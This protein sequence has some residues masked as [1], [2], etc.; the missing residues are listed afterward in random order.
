MKSSRQL[1]ANFGPLKGANANA[2][3]TGP[4]GDTMEFWLWVAE[5]RILQANFTTDGCAASIASGAMTAGFADG[6]TLAAAEIISPDQV[7]RAL[8]GLPP[9]HVHCPL[10]AVNTLQA[11]LA[12]YRAHP[13]PASGPPP[14]VACAPPAAAPS[15]AAPLQPRGGHGLLPDEEQAV[16][17]RVSRIAHKLVVLSGKGGVGKSTVAANLAV[18]L[19]AAGQ[20][21]GLLDVDVHG[22]SIPKLLGLEGRKPEA[23]DEELQPISVNDRL[24]VMSLGFLLVNPQDAIIWRGPMK[25]SAIQELLSAVAWGD[26]DVLVIDSPPGTG[27][28]PLAVAQLIGRPAAAIVVTTP[29]QLAVADVRRSITFCR[30]VGLPVLGLIENM[31]GYVCPQCGVTSALFKTGGGENLAREMKVPFLGTLPIDPQIVEAGD[32]GT[33]WI[34]QFADS[35]SAR[36]FAGLTKSVLRTLNNDMNNETQN[37]TTP[38]KSPLKIAIPLAGGYLAEHFGHCEQFALVDADPNTRNILSTTQVTPPPHEPG[39]LPR[40]LR[41]QGVQVVIAGGIGQRA[42]NLFAQN[43]ITV[44]GGQTA[45][46]VEQLV[47]AY[48]QGQLTGTPQGCVHPPED[49]AKPCA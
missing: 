6:K 34:E 41:E 38:M 2:R 16:R 26:L 45:A 44:R 43:G 21:V 27:D 37:E 39:L 5:G 48:L 1:P 20:Q 3:V 19:A 46:P 31:S 17:Q 25:Y 40:W 7:L 8:G 24:Q 22:P 13:R 36:A 11:A 4:C 32:R 9:D 42:L 28:E 49:H 14:G 35:P 12:D 33:P 30:Q 47:A 15:P 10:L 29:Q 23:N 18:A